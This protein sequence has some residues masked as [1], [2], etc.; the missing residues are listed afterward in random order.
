QHT[1]VGTY[2]DEPYVSNFSGNVIELCPVGALTGRQQRFNFRPWELQN[3]PSICP[4]CAFGC[5]INVSVRKNDEVIRFLSRD[6]PEVDDSWL[7]DRGRFGSEFINSPERLSVPLVRRGDSFVQTSWPMVLD[8]IAGR[9][10]EIIDLNGPEAISGIAS[11]T[12]TNEDLFVFRRFMTDVIGSG[13]VDHYPRPRLDLSGR[14]ERAMDRLEDALMPIAGLDESKTILLL[15][16]DP[17]RREPVME[18]RIRLAVNR[19]DARLLTLSP[20]EIPLSSKSDRSITYSADRYPEIARGL[21]AAIRGKTPRLYEGE[22]LSEMADAFLRDGDVAVLYDDSFEGVLDKGDALAATAEVLD[23][24]EAH[25]HAGV[26]PM[27]DAAN[28]MGSR[29][30]SLL[31]EGRWQAPELERILDPNG[32]VKAALLLGANVASDASEP[33]IAERLRGLDLL[34]VSDL[35]L[36]P[37]ARL[38]DVILPAAS[39]AEKIGTFTNTEGRVQALS[40]VVPSPGLARGEWRML[41]DLSQYFDRP[42]EFNRPEE[43]WEEIQ[44]AVPAYHDISWAD[45]GLRGKRSAAAVPV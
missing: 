32:G 40:E 1:V 16:A 9:L 3:R 27:L 6:N 39:F 10:E 41:V 8:L 34:V 42:L 28:S 33:A 18:L 22:A 35:M 11:S 13:H 43:I 15:G 17:S 23:A 37:T 21:A 29:N 45:V 7:C 38:A 30:L 26:I 31:P 20:D 12:L 19:H 14:Q 2:Q 5:N 4:H 44:R 24:L 25:G 36:T